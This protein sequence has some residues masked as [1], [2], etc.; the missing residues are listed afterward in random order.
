MLEIVL[1]DPGK[2][3]YDYDIT[4]A[5]IYELL[6]QNFKHQNAFQHRSIDTRIKFLSTEDVIGFVTKQWNVPFKIYQFSEHRPF[7]LFDDGNIIAIWYLKGYTTTF[8]FWGDPLF[9]EHFDK[10]RA[11]KVES[12]VDMQWSYAKPNGEIMSKTFKLKNANKAV[13]CHYPFIADGIETFIDDYLASDS[14]ILLL[15]GPPG[16]GK[17]TFIRHLLYTRRIPTMV[18]FDE[19]VMENEQYY[20]DY[21][22][23]AEHNLMIIE[24]ADITLAARSEGQNRLMSKFL[25]VADGVVPLLNKKMIFSTNLENLS[26]ID[27]ALTRP[28]RCFDI[29][30]FRQLSSEEAN[31][32]A[33]HAGLPEIEDSNKEYTLSE[34]LNQQVQK[35]V[36]K[37]KAGF[38]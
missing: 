32:V 27:S 18:T 15:M 16:T 36:N 9:V 31:V 4:Y 2:F 20:I 3:C 11:P 34:I 10:F 24:D 38:I 17:T 30:Q 35:S 22:W 8:K 26:K 25:N 21:M 28:G 19:R 23:D 37:R 1:N 29:I 14:P 7:F 6:L 33:K 5:A 13:D 12:E